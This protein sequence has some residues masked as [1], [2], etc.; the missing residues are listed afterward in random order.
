[1]SANEKY[2]KKYK[3]Y[4]HKYT[5]LKLSRALDKMARSNILLARTRPTDENK[6]NE[7]YKIKD[8]WYRF[9]KYIHDNTSAIPQDLVDIFIT[10]ILQ[11]IKYKPNIPEKLYLNDVIV[12]FAKKIIDKKFSYDDEQFQQLYKKSLEQFA[13]KK[14]N[15]QVELL[16]KKSRDTYQ[17]EVYDEITKQIM[18]YYKKKSMKKN[19]FLD[20]IDTIIII[21]MSRALEAMKETK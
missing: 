9:V 1:M 8:Y 5:S 15:L 2:K 19:V 10:L 16:D 12:N 21:V 11:W 17:K 13:H 7:T 18:K 14:Y 20:H 3:K 6:T 4:K